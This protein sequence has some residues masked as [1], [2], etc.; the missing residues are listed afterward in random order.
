[1]INQIQ[2]LCWDYIY[3]N[4]HI[5][6]YMPSRF[7]NNFEVDLTNEFLYL[8]HDALSLKSSLNGT[9]GFIFTSKGFYTRINSEVFL[10]LLIHSKIAL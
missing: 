7:A 2:A 10:P 8:F 3:A 9:Q 4:P 5:N 6:N 1:M